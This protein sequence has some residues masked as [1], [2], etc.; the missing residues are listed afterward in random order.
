MTRVGLVGV[1]CTSS[2]P[3]SE[4]RSGQQGAGLPSGLPGTP[5]T[6]LTSLSCPCS[7]SRESSTRLQ[8]KPLVVDIGTFA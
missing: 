4:L 2:D 1:A 8:G 7:R 3:H 6:F 5:P